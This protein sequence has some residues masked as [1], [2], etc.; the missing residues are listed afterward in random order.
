[1][2]FSLTQF[3]GRLAGSKAG[4]I[5]WLS[6]LVAILL[7]ALCNL[8]LDVALPERFAQT[9]HAAIV[10]DALAALLAIVIAPFLLRTLDKMQEQVTRQNSELR[11]LHA[12]DRAISGT[13]ELQSVLEIA[14][15]EATVAVD[16]EFGALWLLDGDSPWPKPLESAFY[17]ASPGIQAALTERLGTGSVDLVRR[18]AASRRWQDI[19]EPRHSLPPAPWLR[20]ALAVP[21]M[22]GQ[23]VLGLVQISNRGGRVTP[24][25]GFTEDDQRLLESVAAT[26]AV[27]VQ[28]ARLYQETLRRDEILRGLVARTGDAIA[29]SSDA[30]LLMQILADEAARILPCRRVAV[31]EYS[32]EAAQ[33]TP[34]AAHDDAAARDETGRGRS[35]LERFYA[36]PLLRDVA[37]LPEQITEGRSFNAGEG[38]DAPAFYVP[39]APA[40]LGMAPADA[41]FLTSPGYV[42]ILRSRDRRGIGLLCLL[43]PSPRLKQPDSAGFARALAAQASVALENA[44][45][46]RRTEALLAR[47]Q[48]LQ[49]A[50]GQ[51]AAELDT[52]RVLD[53]VVDSARRV[54]DA[55]GYAVWGRDPETNRWQRQAAWGVQ[56]EDASAAEHSG[57]TALLDTVVS[58]RAPHTAAAPAGPVRAQLALPLL[59]A[60]R[61]TGVMALYSSEP[62][63]FTPDEIGLAQSF[64]NQ[65]ASALEN[66]RL[67]T[68]LQ[69]A[70]V[71]ERHIAGRF[72][73]SLLPTYAPRFG[74][75]EFA[76]KYQAALEEAV[77]GG[78]FF[79]L[80]PLGETRM[81]VVMADVSGKGL[82]AAVQ[83]ALLKYTLRGFALE[84]PDAPA[85]VLARLNDV[86]CS[87]M[88]SHDG[89]VTLFYGVLD[90]ETGALS[91]ASA[92]HEPPLCR[93]GIDGPVTALP[94]C[95]GMVLGAVPGV[96][97]EQC[98]AALA[99]GDLLLL[100][101][102]GLTE[103]RAA[104]GSFLEV[105][106][107][108]ALL[109]RA[110]VSAAEAVAA[111]Y[112]GAAAYADNVRRD[113]VAILVLRRFR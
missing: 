91:Y 104:D 11:S 110:D 69:D 112:D 87:P 84:A 17:A 79:D 8:L 63:T 13:F 83:T 36:Q 38:W 49:A 1:M 25:D 111:L 46:S 81:G 60:G 43:D 95:D 29:A 28:N 23:S 108:S 5:S 22:Q 66:A 59:H 65:A 6:A 85:S 80:F 33:F 56:R 93:R 32:E 3:L 2:N 78:D 107:L 27:A 31:Y 75:F 15:K 4:G 52:D 54:L 100:Y 109:P 90:V 74:A 105:E 62:R 45:L 55:D 50:T 20:N 19:E 89:F 73:E 18:T 42:F 26:V 48:A 101:T 102:D 61:A 9:T 10:S 97:Y 16:G 30:P 99:P 71:R 103:A 92:G 41:A 106:G 57:E 67:F 40:A 68:E 24:L 94:E 113:D 37:D 47:T 39:S 77:I 35:L 51:I 82:G 96:V 53:G 86:L 76:H 44:Q 70:Y 58:V 7:Y 14:V 72:Q 21:I 64:A 12:I 34:L 88:S 98:R